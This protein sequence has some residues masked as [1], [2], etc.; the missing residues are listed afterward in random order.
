MLAAVAIQAVNMKGN[1]DTAELLSRE[2]PRLV[3]SELQVWNYS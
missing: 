2:R 3:S 1:R